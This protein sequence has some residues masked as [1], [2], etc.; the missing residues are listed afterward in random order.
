MLQLPRGSKDNIAKNC[1]EIDIQDPTNIGTPNPTP[2]NTPHNNKSLTN[3]QL[4]S[5]ITHKHSLSPSI[6]RQLVDS[7]TLLHHNRKSNNTVNS[8]NNNNNKKN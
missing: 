7:N 3:N 1:F 6:L 5:T 8:K 2:N 4:V